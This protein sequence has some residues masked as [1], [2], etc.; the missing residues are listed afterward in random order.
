M[1]QL[2]LLALA[3]ADRAVGTSQQVLGRAEHQGER[4]SELVTDV[5]EERRLGSVDLRQCLRSLALVFEGASVAN[6]RDHLGR[7]E[8]EERTV[9]GIELAMRAHTAD[10]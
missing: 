9:A 2:E 3:L 6:C 8:L 1:D 4:R 5:G 7:G 10:E